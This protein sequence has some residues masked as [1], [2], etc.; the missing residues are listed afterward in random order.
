VKCIVRYPATHASRVHWKLTRRGR[1][2]DRGTERVRNGAVAIRIPAR[3]L[4]RGSY[5][6]SATYETPTGTRTIRTLLMAA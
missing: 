3:D 6:L 1:T 2:V 4:R 5:L